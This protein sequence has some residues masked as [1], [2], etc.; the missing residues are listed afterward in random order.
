MMAKA[1]KSFKDAG[2]FDAPLREWEAR[3]AVVQTYANL[4]VLMCVEYSKLNRQDATTARAT[5]HASANNVI[6]EMAQLSL[7]HI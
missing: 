2:D 4:K 1:L 5:G 7:I 6:K 3:P